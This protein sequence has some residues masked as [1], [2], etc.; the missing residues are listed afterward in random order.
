MLSAGVLTDTR[1]YAHT[2]TL[3][4]SH[5]LGASGVEFSWKTLGSRVNANSL[6]LG[7]GSPSSCN[8]NQ[9]MVCSELIQEA[10]TH[11]DNEAHQ[12]FRNFHIKSDTSQQ[13]QHNTTHRKN[14]MFK[15]RDFKVLQYII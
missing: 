8:K 11:R 10:N 3:N 1:N 4:S 2:P 12:F 15:L 5:I 6:D 9:T 13:T 14:G 7:V